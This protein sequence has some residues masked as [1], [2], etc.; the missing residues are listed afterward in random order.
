MQCACVILSSLVCPALQYI[1]TLSH[2][3]HDFWEKVTEHKMCVLIFSTTFGWNISDVNTAGRN[4][5][6]KYQLT[7]T[8]ESIRKNRRILHLTTVAS[9]FL[10]ARLTYNTLACNTLRVTRVWAP[11]GSISSVSHTISKK[12]ILPGIHW[13]LSAWT[14][15]HGKLEQRRMQSC[16]SSY[17]MLWV[18][19]DESL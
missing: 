1:S 17:V 19:S 3:R 12:V 15:T 4:D 7:A 2:K 14:P 8:T 11:L 18:K 13:N 10:S 6:N 16:L 9:H 5:Q